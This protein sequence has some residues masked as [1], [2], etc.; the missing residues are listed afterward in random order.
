MPE[1]DYK[2]MDRLSTEIIDAAQKGLGKIEFRYRSGD[3]ESDILAAIEVIKVPEG[4]SKPS[5]KLVEGVARSRKTVAILSNEGTI[6][7]EGNKAI[8]RAM[9]SHLAEL[10]GVTCENLEAPENERIYRKEFT[11]KE[12]Y[13]PEE[14][15]K[16]R[17]AVL[18]GEG[19]IILGM[20][21]YS[22]IGEDNCR[23]WGVSEDAYTA[24]C[25]D[26]LGAAINSL[27]RKF[28]GIRI[29][30]V[31]GA[32]DMGVDKGVIEVADTMGLNHLGFSCPSYMFYV[33]DD[34]SP[35]YVARTKDEY[36]DCF[37]RSLDMLFSVG[38][39]LQALKHDMAAALEHGK[40]LLLLNVLEVI[41]P[42]GG[43]P[44]RD[45]S[46]RIV[47]ATAAFLETVLQLSPKVGGGKYEDLRNVVEKEVV[48]VAGKLLPP[49]IAYSEW[50]RSQ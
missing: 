20:T 36:A 39:R 33:K 4:L 23:E 37:V 38:G 22:K 8:V 17:R 42:H 1:I 19:L 24:A 32:S 35:V 43:P 41:S 29:A 34:K 40:K 46:G 9:G 3:D 2:G 47:D 18:S 27:Q 25:S 14:Y 7:R 45:S 49:Q 44:A 6:H 15:E 28:K 10:E 11:N 21:G 31:D 12:I 48:F 16:A 13:L 30:L 26:L 5:V 50:K